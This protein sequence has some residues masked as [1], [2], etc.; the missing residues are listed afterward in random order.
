MTSDIIKTAIAVCTLAATASQFASAAEPPKKGNKTFTIHYLYHPV[1]YTEVP[2]V[3]KVTTLESAGQIENIKGETPP[4]KDAMKAKCQMVSIESGGKGWT[5]G[6]CITT[7]G[8]GDLIFATFD[9]RNL[10]KSQPKM[11]C[12]SYVDTGG[13]GKF[14]GISATGSYTCAMAEA[15]KG[16][17][18]GSFAMDISH[19]ES[20]QM[21]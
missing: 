20:W 14:K 1:G 2:G 4:F 15:P 12:G 10:D 13:T 5:E 3:G 6:A 21:N 19:N 8:D 17:P 16:E 18:A 11:D 9:S 7:D